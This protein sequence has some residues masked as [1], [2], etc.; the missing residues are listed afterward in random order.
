MVDFIFYNYGDIS[1]RNFSINQEIDPFIK[2]EQPAL[3][4]HAHTLTVHFL[5]FTVIQ[6]S[7]ILC[8]FDSFDFYCYT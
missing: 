7:Y 4:K 5:K 8:I 3:L 1:V 6:S 2:T